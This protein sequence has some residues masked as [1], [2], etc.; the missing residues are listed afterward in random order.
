[1]SKLIFK[2]ED[3]RRVVEHSIAS[4][5][6]KKA[7]G[8]D[9][10]KGDVVTAEVT[11]ASVLLVHDHGVYLMSNGSPRDIIAPDGEDKRDEK[12]NEGRSYCA[13]AEG[14]DPEKDG[15]EAFDT[16]NHLVG[17]DD[18]GEC[19]DWADAMKKFIDDGAT[20]IVINYT[21]RNLSLSAKFPKGKAPASGDRVAAGAMDYV[22]G[23]KR[24]MKTKVV[25]LNGTDEV[26]VISCAPTEVNILRV[27]AKWSTYKIMNGMKDDELVKIALAVVAKF[28]R[29]D[30]RA[31]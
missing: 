14:C 26:R 11:K 15:D 13:Y 2:A 25:A 21:Q 9:S 8:F 16:S 31:A 5:Q 20:H 19:L 22:K 6:S 27:K 29:E 17:G 18:F 30:A 1:M 24:K 12:K 28:A 3:V 10:K 23:W 7:V 4:K